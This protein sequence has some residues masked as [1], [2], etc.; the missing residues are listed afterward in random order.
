[1]STR[2]T[3]APVSWDIA[4]R[5]SKWVASCPFGSPKNEREFHP[6]SISEQDRLEDM[7][8]KISIRAE[9]LVIEH[10][11]LIPS[12]T[13]VPC[14]EVLD[15]QQWSMRNLRTFQTILDHAF[16]GSTAHEGTYSSILSNNLI[17]GPSSWATGMELGIS[18]GW[19]SYR[20][21]GQYDIFGG[22]YGS[23]IES[24]TPTSPGSVYYVGPNILSLQ[25]RHGFDL[26][27]FGLW[28]ALHETT[29][30]CQLEGV[31][32]LRPYLLEI[33]DH[34]LAAMVVPDPE[35]LSAAIKRAASS[36]T[37]P[38]DLLSQGGLATLFASDEQLDDI[39]KLQAAMSLLE[40]HG[41][42]VMDDAATDIREEA[43][44]FS[45]V[46]KE[47]R[48]SGNILVRFFQELLGIKAK[49]LQYE[50][51]ASFLRELQARG[52]PE[53]TSLVWQEP[54]NL[55]S[56]EELDDPNLWL[57]RMGVLTRA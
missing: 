42:V 26:Y 8:A 56:L 25:R 33:V 49:L 45:K 12:I 38:R 5:T 31:P 30:R 44:I 29:H 13:G 10:T 28:I 37:S 46:L 50:K 54:A 22:G 23:E 32:W 27:P 53:I 36:T 34:L 7:F 4:A 39:K 35:R 9:E 48:K 16:A 15:R 43:E 2:P 47:R 57:E 40:G 14:A 6:V 20:V 52:D 17:L 41:D 21:L 11:G 18:V 55:P 19:L 3:K 1:M 24:I 51:G